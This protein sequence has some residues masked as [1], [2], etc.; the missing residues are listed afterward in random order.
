MLI[1][2]FSTSADDGL[3]QRCTGAADRSS[4]G[5]IYE[6]LLPSGFADAENTSEM[7]VQKSEVSNSI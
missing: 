6:G 4:V 7:G 5:V 2:C 1:L 3:N